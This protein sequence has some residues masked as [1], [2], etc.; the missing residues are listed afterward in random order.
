MA[1]EGTTCTF[2]KLNGKGSSLST[3]SNSTTT[4]TANTKT[5]SS[6]RPKYQCLNKQYGEQQRQSLLVRPHVDDDNVH[7]LNTSSSYSPHV[8]STSVCS[9]STDSS[10]APKQPYGIDVHNW[11]Y[12]DSIQSNNK[13]SS[14]TSDY[15]FPDRSKRESLITAFPNV[16]HRASYHAVTGKHVT[17]FEDQAENESL[18]DHKR[19]SIINDKANINELN[20]IKNIQQTYDS[21]KMDYVWKKFVIEWTN[22]SKPHRD[23][24][25][26]FE[27][28]QYSSRVIR[29]ID[30][31]ANSS[32]NYD[33]SATKPEWTLKHL[34]HVCCDF[35]SM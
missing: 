6:A 9:T 2:H 26:Q 23:L 28:N 24:Q 35:V 25:T 19:R 1:K 27:V 31:S 33:C 16:P 21:L 13:K 17:R 20:L 22:H 3:A 14:L 12:R 5:N 18:L 4:T 7:W 8:E 11:S 15:D 30:K 32:L 29:D 34:T 10:T